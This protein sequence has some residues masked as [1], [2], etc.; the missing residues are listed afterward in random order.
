MICLFWLSN[1]NIIEGNVNFGKTLV[2]LNEY[3]YCSAKFSGKTNLLMFSQNHSASIFFDRCVSISNWIKP[4]KRQL[5]KNVN[6][7]CARNV[8]TISGFKKVTS[9]FPWIL[10]ASIFEF[11][12]RSLDH[13]NHLVK[14]LRN[15][16]LL[17][18]IADNH[19]RFQS[20]AMTTINAENH[21]IQSLFVLTLYT[22]LWYC[23]K[24]KRHYNSVIIKSKSLVKR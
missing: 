18:Q 10:F 12:S 16:L 9:I 1:N 7:Q 5:K 6:G 24:T 15:H 2:L 3:V 14:I 8:C 17:T 22:N 20:G 23:L 21:N 13:F 19:Y 4:E 11:F